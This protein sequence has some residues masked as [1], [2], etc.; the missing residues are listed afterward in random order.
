MS[1]IVKLL[2]MSFLLSLSHSLYAIDLH[3]V[4]EKEFGDFW[5]KDRPLPV[6]IFVVSSWSDPH[7]RIRCWG[8]FVHPDGSLQ[9][10]ALGDAV[11]VLQ[12]PLPKTD[13][14]KSGVV[15]N[16]IRLSDGAKIEDV[17][18]I[19]AP[20]GSTLSWARTYSSSEGDWVFSHP[21]FKK[22]KIAQD[23]NAPGY[24]TGTD[25]AGFKWESMSFILPDGAEFVWVKSDKWNSY[26][27]ST[28]KIYSFKEKKDGSM[29]VGDIY[30]NTYEYALDGQL[31][32][33]TTY[34]TEATNTIYTNGRLTQ[35]SDN[36]NHSLTLFYSSNNNVEFVESN[37]GPV[38]HYIYDDQNRLIKVGYGTN[39][40]SAPSGFIYTQYLYENASYLRAL[41]GIV[42]AKGIR[43]ATW[44]Y[45][46]QGRAIESFH[47]N[48]KDYVFVDYT[49]FPQATLV[50][51]S[52]GKKT[53]YQF[54]NVSNIGWQISHVTGLETPS[55]L[56][57]N[58]YQSF[59]ADGELQTQ[60]DKNGVVTLYERDSKGRITKQTRGL[61]WP[62]V[63]PRSGVN[64]VT[65]D[66]ITPTNPSELEVIQTCWHPQFPLQS[67]I[68]EA[69]TVTLF[70][71]SAK[72]DLI[73]KSVKPR[74]QGTVTCDSAI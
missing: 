68:I 64:V 22:K 60:T 43:Y 73:S 44:T 70:E 16:P 25:S 11:V 46:S 40:L 35:I 66:L 4:C 57:D 52:L 34:K 62:T 19:S 59:F 10:M 1:K 3:A 17:T 6:E 26:S 45:N 38:V 39:R 8:A 54:V 30:G 31:I 33:D 61:R 53:F 58:M 63:E 13:C 72:G 7:V 21:A 23:A 51:N 49:M 37:W 32:S 24:S 5:R 65:S 56:A 20:V 18:D 74:P 29:V 15:G 41:T 28:S 42:D 27:V 55:C 67:R 47:G 12:Q 14:N 36:T 69:K 48:K 71:Y 50:T 2:L 9:G